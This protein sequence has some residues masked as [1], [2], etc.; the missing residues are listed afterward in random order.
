VSEALGEPG[1]I[2]HWPG[3]L[4]SLGDHQVYLR[5]VPPAGPPATREPASQAPAT[6]APATREPDSREPALCVHGL[7]GSSRNW[8]DLMDLLRPRLAAEA[9]DL[10]GFGDSPP[11]PGGRYSIAA[12]AETITRVIQQRDRG[13]VHLIGNSLSGP[14]CVKVAAADPELIRSLTL[15]S[16]AL[17]DPRPRRDLLH[18]PVMCLPGVGARLIGQFRRL[19]PERRVADVIWNCFSDPQRFAPQRFA[20]EVAELCRRDTFAWPTAALV[21]SART[22]TAD[23]FRVGR[24]SSWREAN[25]IQAPT[26][27]IYGADDRLVHA[28][29]AGRAARAF[30]NARIVVM[31]STGHLAHMEHPAQVAAEINALLDAQAKAPRPNPRGPEQAREFPLTH[32]G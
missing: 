12:M 11:R 17:P 23:Y 18:F 28:R 19:P 2:P 5:S 26:L 32:A 30:K 31:A 7:E 29:N 21:G 9:V 3:R 16:P 20:V 1:P 14:A 10:P 6:Q 27:V 13:P 24:S 15:I 25:R 22:L 4:F 8:T